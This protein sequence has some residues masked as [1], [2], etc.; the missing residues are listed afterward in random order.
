MEFERSIRVG[1]LSVEIPPEIACPICGNMM[2]SWITSMGGKDGHHLI[3]NAEFFVNLDDMPVEKVIEEWSRTYSC[4]VDAN[5]DFEADEA[6]GAGVVTFMQ[7][8]EDFIVVC[9]SSIHKSKH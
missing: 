5:S 1:N 8:D 4:R 2:K 9:P 7:V 6:A 3:A